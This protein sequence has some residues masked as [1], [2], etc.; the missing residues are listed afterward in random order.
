MDHKNTSEN[1][2]ACSGCQ[3][4]NWWATLIVAVIAVPSFGAAVAVLSGTRGVLA[5]AIF[6][7]ACWFCTYLGMKLMHNPKMMQKIEL[8]KK[9]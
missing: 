8:T 2:T 3:G 5:I 4:I 1:S 9:P 6:V 7:I